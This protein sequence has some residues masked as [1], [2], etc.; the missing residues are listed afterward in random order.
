MNFALYW[1]IFSLGLVVLQAVFAYRARTL[2]PS[3]MLQADLLPGIPFVGHLGMWGDVAIITPLLHA[4]IEQN[5]DSW[6]PI[7]VLVCMAIGVAASY[8]MHE[9]YK[10]A[11]CPESHV[12]NGQLTDV[13]H[14]HRVYMAVAIGIILLQYF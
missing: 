4:M 11:K 14:V 7:K 1:V 3:Q 6:K 8:F 12:M 10:G 13:G 9:S 5:S 2:F